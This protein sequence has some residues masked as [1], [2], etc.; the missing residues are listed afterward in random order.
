[1]NTRE[2]KR[3]EVDNLAMNFFSVS[4]SPLLFASRGHF[5]IPFTR[6]GRFR[7]H[8]FLIFIFYFPLFSSPSLSRMLVIVVGNN[9]GLKRSMMHSVS[10]NWEKSVKF[11]ANF[12]IFHLNARSLTHPSTINYLANLMMYSSHYRKFVLYFFLPFSLTHSNVQPFRG[13]R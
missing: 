13:R 5:L 3:V 7:I 4:F 11:S 9:D 12:H 10:A 8:E 2:K 6:F 1:M